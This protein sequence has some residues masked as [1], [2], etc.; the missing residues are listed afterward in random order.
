MGGMSYLPSNMHE[1]YAFDRSMRSKDN[2]G[3]LFIEQTNLC[4]ACVSPYRGEEIPDWQALGLKADAIYHLLRDPEELRK[5]A[6]TGGEKPLLILHKPVSANDHP[7]E[8]TVG[9][10]GSTLAYEHPY[11]KGSMAIWDEQGV[12]AVESKTQSELSPGYRYRADMTPGEYEGVHFDGVMRDIFFN[13]WALVDIGRQGS[14][15]VVADKS[16]FVIQYTE[17]KMAK[18]TPK[19]GV[20]LGALRT[21]LAPRIAQD[22]KLDVASFLVDTDTA[23]IVTRVTT[24]TQGKLGKDQTLIGLDEAMEAAKKDAKDAFP[25]KECTKDEAPDDETEEEKEKRLKKEKEDREDAKD[26]KA[27]D[28]FPDKKKDDDKVDKPA[29]DAAIAASVSKAV[30][31]AVAATNALH[32]AREEVAPLVGK[33]AL[34]SAEAVYAFALKQQGIDTSGVHPSAFPAM[35]KMAKASKPGQA[36]MAHDRAPVVNIGKFFPQSKRFG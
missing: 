14:D 8:L 3:H 33:V 30:A 29:M 6:E 18:L 10:I 22:H 23:K 28:E 2:D 27:R 35:V 16:P 9:T 12:V 31:E 20:Y 11:L 17:P 5:A 24:A 21:F 19:A 13:H 7:R 4:K 34:D 1:K 26:K 25:D 36:P 32:A 15:I